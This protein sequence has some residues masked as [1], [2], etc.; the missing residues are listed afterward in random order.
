[1]KTRKRKMAFPGLRNRI[2]AKWCPKA[3]HGAAALLQ[4]LL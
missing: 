4:N 2:A 1:M 3:P